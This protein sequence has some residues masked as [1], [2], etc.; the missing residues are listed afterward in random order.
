MK[1]F[2]SGLAFVARRLSQALLVMFAILVIAFAVRQGLGDPLL[3][4]GFEPGI[5]TFVQRLVH[6]HR[7]KAYHRIITGNRPVTFHIDDYY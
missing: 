4:D 3:T 5:K 1:A 6:N 7:T 2:V